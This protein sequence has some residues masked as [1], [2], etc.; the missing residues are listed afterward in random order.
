MNTREY[1]TTRLETNENKGTGLILL[2]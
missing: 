2:F 1:P